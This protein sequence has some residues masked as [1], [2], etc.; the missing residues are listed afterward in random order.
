MGKN[1]LYLHENSEKLF[2]SNE[3][4]YNKTIQNNEVKK[5]RE[6]SNAVNVQ[7][8][9]IAR[10]IVDNNS[11]KKSLS[12]LPQLKSSV[13]I[14]ND[15]IETMELSELQ[16]LENHGINVLERLSP[17]LALNVL[18]RVQQQLAVN[19]NSYLITEISFQK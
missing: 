18:A 3:M 10:A 5:L 4:L 17:E 7:L 14:Y 6:L 12:N 19:E 11:T 16:S 9:F 8:E 15:K 2:A 1:A 13:S